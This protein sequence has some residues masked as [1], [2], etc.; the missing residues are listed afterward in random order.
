MVSY[1]ELT[2]AEVL[3]ALYNNA[4]CV[5]YS[6]QHYKPG[7][8]TIKEAEYLLKLTTFYDHLFARELKINLKDNHEFDETFYD[9]DNGK[10]AAQRAIDEFIFAKGINF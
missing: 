5:N 8:L 1:G 4:T 2:K 10:G 9:R 3:C 6:S 7:D